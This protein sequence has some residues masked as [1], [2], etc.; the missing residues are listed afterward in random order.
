M[1]VASFHVKSIRSIKNSTPV[2]LAHS[3]VLVG[4]NESGKTA[5]LRALH[6][7]KSQVTSQSGQAQR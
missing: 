6:G 2:Y 7:V 1:R 5:L 3:T 4:R